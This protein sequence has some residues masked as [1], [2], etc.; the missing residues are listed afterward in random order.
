MPTLLR[1]V[2][3]RLRLS[4]RSFFMSNVSEFTLSIRTHFHSYLSYLI[5]VLIAFGLV[6]MPPTS[7]GVSREA[8]SSKGPGIGPRCAIVPSTPMGVPAGGRVSFQASNCGSGTVTWRLSG[9]GTLDNYG[10]YTAPES[11][12]VQD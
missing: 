11:V 1:V 6:A 10:N 2:W 8:G 7:A 9:P 12:K 4:W 5:P 3:P